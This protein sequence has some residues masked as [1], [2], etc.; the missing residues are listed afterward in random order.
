[1]ESKIFTRFS[2][3]FLRATFESERVS[4]RRLEL[5]ARSPLIVVAAHL[6]SKLRWSNASQ[7]FECVE[8]ASQIA[9]EEDRAGH[10]RTVLLGDF[11]MNPF[12][13]GIV[14]GNGLNAVMSQKI[15]AR[16]TRRVQG[17]DYRFFYNPM[18]AHMGD[19]HR[20]T[21]GSYFYDR[22]EHVNYFW[23]VFDQVLIRPELVSRFDPSQ[24]NIFTAVG[25]RSMVRPDGRPDRVNFSDHLPLIFEV[26]F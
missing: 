2:R 10:T 7:A 8:L 18:W 22:A 23:N 26:D 14:A 13:E 4:I 11:N 21:A 5:P 16:L 15:A 19:R 1:M 20:D 24:V 25:D 17:R 9:A 12:E 3:D 6:P